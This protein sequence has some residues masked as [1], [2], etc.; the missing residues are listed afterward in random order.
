MPE[1]RPS[2]QTLNNIWSCKSRRLVA[3]TPSEIPTGNLNLGIAARLRTARS[4]W[5]QERD[6]WW[7]MY[8]TRDRQRITEN[9]KNSRNWLAQQ[10]NISRNTAWVGMLKWRAAGQPANLFSIPDFLEKKLL[11]CLGHEAPEWPTRNIGYYSNRDV[12]PR[13]RRNG[14]RKIPPDIHRQHGNYRPDWSLRSGVLK[15]DTG[16]AIHGQTCFFAGLG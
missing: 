1:T 13:G 11:R 15:L 16:V 6:R 4:F 2:I 10:H 14:E 5:F 9:R 7:W 12:V 8:C 3:K